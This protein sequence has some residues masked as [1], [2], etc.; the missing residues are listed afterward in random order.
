[1]TL[2]CKCGKSGEIN[3]IL[4]MILPVG[5]VLFLLGQ[6]RVLP[7][8]AVIITVRYRGMLA[9]CYKVFQAFYR[10][11]CHSSSRAWRSSPRF[12]GGLS[13][14]VIARPN[15]SQI[16]FMGLQSGD[17]AGGPILMTLPC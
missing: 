17:L 11:F 6:Y 1:M 12:W 4:C 14:L 5:V 10:D 3:F 9:T 13:I 16:C 8:Q 15:S 2:G 7:A